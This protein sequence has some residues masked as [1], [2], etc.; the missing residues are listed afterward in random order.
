MNC[1]PKSIFL[2]GATGFIGGTILHSLHHSHPEIRIKALIR[3]EEDAKSLQYVYPNLE[4]VI[5]TLS[6]LDLL[7]TTAKDVDFVINAAREN[8]PAVHAMI[9]GLASSPIAGPPTPR[10]MSLSGTRSL[11]DPSLPVTGVGDPDSRP[12]SD[13]ADAK[14]IL[15]LPKGRP[16]A[17]ADQSIIA[18]GIAKGVGV[19]L[20]SPGQQWGRGKGHL[21]KESAAAAYYAAVKSRG[22]AFVIGDG[23][24]AWSWSSTG[25]LGDAVTFLMKGAL[26]SEHEESQLGVNEEGY[27]FVQSGDVS[28]MERAEAVSKRIGLGAVESVP[29]EVA[30]EFHAFGPLMWGC[31]ATF[32]ADKLKALGWRPKET[33][34]RPLM[35]EEGGERA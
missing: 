30:A 33:D 14:T 19:M 17:E 16:H 9:D 35:E 7:T 21:K 10:L 15:N 5:G 34:W 24:V 22:R 27:Y 25:D 18:H 26:L 32:R 13:I 20:I 23:S 29:V 3:R 12:W 11:I 31:G 8:I 6:S 4:P 1:T 2:T 28:M